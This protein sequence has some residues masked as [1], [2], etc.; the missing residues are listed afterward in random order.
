[1]A[2]CWLTMDQVSVNHWMRQLCGSTVLDLS[3]L[4]D[5][6]ADFLVSIDDLGLEYKLDGQRLR[7]RKRI[8]LIDVDSL[9]FG[10]AQRDLKTK[11]QYRL[12]TKSTNL[13]VIA[14]FDQKAITSIATCEKQTD[15][16]GRRGNHWIS[17][18]GQNI[19]CTVGVLK[20]IKP[21]NLGLL[22]IVTGLAICRALANFGYKAVTLK[23]PNDL[24]HQ[25]KKLG[26][27]LIE[28][29]PVK[30]DEYF[31]AIGFGINVDMSN[32]ALATIE[33]AATCLNLID[34]K[35]LTRNQIL[36]ETVSQVL[37]DIAAFSDES[38]SQ[39]VKAFDAIDAFKGMP[40]NVL[41]SGKTIAG[42]NAGIA[43][44][45]QLQ[46]KTVEGMMLFS[47]ADISLRRA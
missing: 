18:F 41:S 16:K 20:T 24:Y 11:C 38:I 14:L 7:L 32:E 9:Q 6:R 22:S 46:L 2:G 12:E 10:L 33:P 47:A 27:I 5:H 43:Q 25:G 44:T 31:L 1:M 35:L 21:S 37:K 23:W 29:R 30:D 45:G 4:G 3:Q 40:V 42:I 17:P 39:L 28:S 26:G 15:G 8:E 34:S 13:D 36:L 19:Y